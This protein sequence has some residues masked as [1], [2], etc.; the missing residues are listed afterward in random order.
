VDRSIFN[1]SDFIRTNIDGTHLLMDAVRRHGVPR[2]VHISTDEVYGSIPEGITG[3]DAPLRPSNP[4]S[5]SKACADML[6]QSYIST[7]QAPAVIIRGSN[8]YGP[9]QYPEKLIPLAVSNL[10]EKKKIPV[11][12]DGG[13]VRSWLHVEDFCAAVD[14]VLHRARP[15]AIYNVSGE[16]KTNLE[17]LEMI[18][19]AIGIPAGPHLAHTADRPGADRRYAPDPSKLQREIGWRRRHT[20]EQ[21]IGEV[22]DWYVKNQDW[23]KKIK[24]KREYQDHYAK[25]AQGRWY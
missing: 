13:H 9:H 12:G 6:V 11:H 14:A 22:A 7:H 3:E 24:A 16:E 8:N 25:Q 15:G 20:I 5:T 18:G 10:I 23:W 17:I 19:T 21:S 4:Y 2:M 1:V